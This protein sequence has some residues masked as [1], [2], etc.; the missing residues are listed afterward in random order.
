VVVFKIFIGSHK[1]QESQS[2]SPDWSRPSIPSQRVETLSILKNGSG[3]GVVTS[4]PAGIDCGLDCS[5]TL[6]YAGSLGFHLMKI[7][8]IYQ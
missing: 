5:E 1:I 4:N 6:D 3:S 8:N 2:S 7:C